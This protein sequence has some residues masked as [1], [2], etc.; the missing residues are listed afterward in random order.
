[1]PFKFHEAQ[2]HDIPKAC[3]RV[4]NWSDYDRGL[5]RHGDIRI[6]LSD[7]AITGITVSV[8]RYCAITVTVH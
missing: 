4:R 3:Y 1:M 8:L 5:V 6:W 7:E 2:R